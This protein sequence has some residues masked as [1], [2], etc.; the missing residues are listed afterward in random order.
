MFNCMQ[1]DARELDTRVEGRRVPD[2]ARF[3]EQAL[4]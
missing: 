4:H 1:N 3:D 2:D